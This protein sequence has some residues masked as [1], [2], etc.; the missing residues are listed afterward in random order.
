MHMKLFNLTGFFLVVAAFSVQADK[1][2]HD[3][4]HGEGKHIHGEGTVN[5]VM[6]SPTVGEIEVDIPGMD[7][8]GFEHK[9][10][11]KEDKAKIAE[12]KKAWSAKP[13]ELFVFPA[14]AR[15]TVKVDEVEWEDE[16]H[17]D[18]GKKDAKVHHH[19]LH[20]K[21]D[22]ACEKAPK[23]EVKINVFSLAKALSKVHFQYVG[24]GAQKAQTLTSSS[25][26]VQL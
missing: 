7:V 19:A 26:K 22:V 25:S 11:S 13:A 17:H 23:G 12:L 4:H 3:D 1:H 8:V 9:A 10:T 16:S 5:L 2:D 20:A 24:Q 21:Y 15:C 14:D 18:K 6:E